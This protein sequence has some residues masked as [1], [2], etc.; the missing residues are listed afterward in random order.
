VTW[1]YWDLLGQ[2]FCSNFGEIC[3]TVA[4]EALPWVW[5]ELESIVPCLLEGGTIPG[6]ILPHEVFLG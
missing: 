6:M 3:I 2:S 4:C 5:L 1:Q